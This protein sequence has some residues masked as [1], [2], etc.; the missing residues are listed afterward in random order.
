MTPEEAEEKFTHPIL[1]A[2]MA[3]AGEWFKDEPRVSFHDAVAA[4]CIFHDDVCTWKQGDLSVEL[5]SKLLA[6]MTFFRENENG[7]HSVAWDINES[8]FFKHL[9]EVFN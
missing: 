1:K 9:F 5:E 2:V 8:N 6:G 3:I 4:V 7:A